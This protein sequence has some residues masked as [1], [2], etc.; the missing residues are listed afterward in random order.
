[1][2][3]NGM[4]SKLKLTWFMSNISPMLVVDVRYI[5]PVNGTKATSVF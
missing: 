1:M 3:F 2:E 5:D 4:S